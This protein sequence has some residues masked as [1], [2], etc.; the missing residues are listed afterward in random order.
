MDNYKIVIDPGHGGMDSGA[1]LEKYKEKDFTMDIS[2][3]IRD[4]L[5]K[6]KELDKAYLD[7]RKWNQM[8]LINT[9]S[10]GIFAADRS[11]EEYAQNI[12]ELK[13]VK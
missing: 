9:A 7:K 4:Y 12:W 11:I 8:S 2:L 1:I 5:E 13:K 3:K 10:A 6:T